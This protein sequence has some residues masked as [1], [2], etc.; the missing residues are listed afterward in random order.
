VSTRPLHG[1]ES[2]KSC[3]QSPVGDG[4]RAVIKQHVAE[5]ADQA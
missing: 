5:A 4:P 3:C 2:F 1:R